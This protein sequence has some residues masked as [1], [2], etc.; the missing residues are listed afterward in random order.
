VR[1]VVEI[2]ADEYVHGGIPLVGGAELAEDLIAVV[3]AASALV[4]LAFFLGEAGS[5]VR[6]DD[7]Q[8]VTIDFDVAFQNPL[9]PAE[10]L[11][12]VALYGQPGDDGRRN[13]PAAVR[14]LE[15]DVMVMVRLVGQPG[16]ESLLE[17]FRCPLAFA[18]GDGEDVRPTAV[19]Q[20]NE[21]SAQMVW[22]LAEDL[23]ILGKPIVELLVRLVT[24]AVDPVVEE[25]LDVPE[26]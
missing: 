7:D 25:V 14:V 22:L 24:P 19:V 23:R 11:G 21:R 13:V 20:C 16:V 1:R 18:L 17:Q 15:Q 12:P 9:A 10:Q 5:P 6:G 4:L 3:V 26:T 2:A 8:V